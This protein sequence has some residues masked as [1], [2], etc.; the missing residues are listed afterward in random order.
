MRTRC[1]ALLL[2]VTATGA[3]LPT[4]DGPDGST[5]DAELAHDAP[6]TDAH[7]TRPA[8]PSVGLRLPDI[9]RVPIERLDAS[10]ADAPIADAP[11]ADTLLTDT[12]FTDT[13]RTDASHAEASATDAPTADAATVDASADLV[14]ILD[15]PPDLTRTDVASD[16][17]STTDA[18]DATTV[19]VPGS[20]RCVANALR[21]CSADG[22]TETDV[23]CPARSTC[24]VD[25]CEPWTCTPGEATCDGPAYRSVCQADGLGTARELCPTVPNILALSCARGVCGFTCE[26][27]WTDCDGVASNGCE[28]FTWSDAH[29]CGRC[30]NA[31]PAAPGAPALCIATGCVQRCAEGR[32]DCNHDWSDGCE[33]DPSRDPLHCNGCDGRCSVTHGVPACVDG[34]CRVGACG[35]GYADC[36]GYLSNGCEVDLTTSAS[37][38]GRCGNVCPS[39]QTCVAGTCA[40]RPPPITCGPR[41]APRDG[42][43]VPLPATCCVASAECNDGDPFTD[44]TC[45]LRSGACEHRRARCD[46]SHP[47][48]DGD[49][50]TDNVCT[51]GVCS[52]PAITPQCTT[53]AACVVYGSGSACTASVCIGGRCQMAVPFPTCFSNPRVPCGFT[54]VP[55]EGGRCWDCQPV[56]DFAGC[57]DPSAPIPACDDGDPTTFD[58]CGP[59]HTCSHTPR[60]ACAL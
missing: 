38:C 34:Y 26:P 48:D 6:M 4:P 1:F 54:V 42:R 31:C 56:P 32:L 18:R 11:R 57:C 12:S 23:P 52:Y 53:S 37:N 9:V 25:H 19:C 35:T 16:L 5:T 10:T 2:A 24:S 8:P 20:T 28:T 27:G 60:P 21:T 46:T 7:D 39:G 43:C 22:R 33:V 29:N 59:S 40:T 3:C 49:A 17:P 36:D 15:A 55:G 58:E 50:T 41:Q 44:D 30:G 13:S 47:C 45:G 51:A 14:T